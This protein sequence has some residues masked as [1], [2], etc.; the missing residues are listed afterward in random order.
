[1]G[2]IVFR[3]FITNETV[4]FETPAKDAMSDIVIRF[5]RMSHFL[6]ANRTDTLKPV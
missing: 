4:D 1:M 3:E 5:I 2:I 6:P